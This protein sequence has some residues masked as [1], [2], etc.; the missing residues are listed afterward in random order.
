MNIL[1]FAKGYFCQVINQVSKKVNSMDTHVWL[2]TFRWS[3]GREE[4][5]TVW[6]IEIYLWNITVK[7]LIDNQYSLIFLFL[8]SIHFC[9]YVLINLN[10]FL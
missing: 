1:L 7:M 3:L 10:K 4:F 9:K 8:K 2:K 5:V 6:Q